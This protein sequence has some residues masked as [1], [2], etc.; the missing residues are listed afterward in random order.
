MITEIPYADKGGG[1]TRPALVLSSYEHNQ[2]RRDLVVAKISGTGAFSAWDVRINK[3]P[4]AGLMKP[5][6]VV[7]DHITVVS[8][9]SAIVIGH[10]DTGTLAG[11]KK[12]VGLLLSL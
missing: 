11:V 1:K 4:E 2:N 12:K 3:W 8:K 5:S 6:K 7:C 9:A 10:I